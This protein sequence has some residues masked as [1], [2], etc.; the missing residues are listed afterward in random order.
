MYV[1]FLKIEQDMIAYAIR[2]AE[3]TGKSWEV[4]RDGRGALDIAL[5]G[6]C[7]CCPKFRLLVTIHP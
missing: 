7:A 1:N 2:M 6:T 5:I 4:F 3:Q